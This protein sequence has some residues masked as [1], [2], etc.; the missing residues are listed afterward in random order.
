GGV[1][2]RMTIDGRAPGDRSVD[3]RDR[4]EQL[5]VAARQRL[6][7]RQLIEIARVVVVDRAPE[8]PAQVAHRFLGPARRSDDRL[9]LRQHVRRELRIEP[10][11][12]HGAERDVLQLRSIGR[13]AHLSSLITAVKSSMRASICGWWV[14]KLSTQ[15][16]PRERPW[17]AEPGTI[18][19]PPGLARRITAPVAPAS[20]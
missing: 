14:R 15:T 10:A 7:D 12:A 19:P 20:S 4:D 6:G 1:L 13:R 9:D 3:I 2:R 5:H 18:P 17:A 16:R 8:E 11:F